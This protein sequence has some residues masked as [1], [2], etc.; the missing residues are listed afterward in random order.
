LE[1][2]IAERQKLEKQV[3][4]VRD[5][6]QRRFSQDLHDGLGQYLIGI[7]FRISA[8]QQD[9]EATNSPLAVD[10]AEVLAL[11]KDASRQA[12][13]LARGVHPVP[14]RPDG[15][16]IALQEL[17]EKL[18]HSTRAHCVFECEEPVHIDNNATATHLYRIAQEAITNA[19]KH[20]DASTIVVRLRNL[21]DTAE[22]TVADDGAG[23]QADNQPTGGRGLNIM[24]HRARLIDASLE[25]GSGPTGGTLVRCTFRRTS[26]S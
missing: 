22:L 4:E 2:Q 26:N 11:L 19:I 17:V 9:L 21:G 13:D 7:E 12:H 24:R 8:L 25:I 20:A 23:F 10:A 1:A 16:V 14:L 5:Q 15:L 6:E 18:C 3:F